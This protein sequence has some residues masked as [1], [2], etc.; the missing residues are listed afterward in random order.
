MICDDDEHGPAT[1]TVRMWSREP[2]F[3]TGQMVPNSR[4]QLSWDLLGH[5]EL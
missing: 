2:P 3:D 1:G 4:P 5:A